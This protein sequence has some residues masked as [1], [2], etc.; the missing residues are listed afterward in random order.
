[1]QGNKLK[2]TKE[3]IDTYL[4]GVPKLDFKV[5]A[6]ALGSIPS[7]V[8]QFSY[9]VKQGIMPVL[10]NQINIIRAVPGSNKAATEAASFLPTFHK[11]E[12]NV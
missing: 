10:E 1:M 6:L 12:S 8:A 7:E 2:I 3:F 11:A 9:E 4:Q 5:I